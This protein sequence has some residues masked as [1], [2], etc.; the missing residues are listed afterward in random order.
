MIRA[1]AASINT[2]RHTIRRTCSPADG[3]RSATFNVKDFRAM[4]SL[5][6]QLGRPLTLRLEGPGLPLVVEPAFGEGEQLL[7][8]QLV[9]ATLVEAAVPEPMAPMG[10][11]G[12]VEEARLA[13]A[14][15]AGNAG[16][17][18]ICTPPRLALLA[19]RGWVAA[20]KGVQ[21]L[22]GAGG[23]RLGAR[24]A[25]QHTGVR[26]TQIR[27]MTP[28]GRSRVEAVPVAG[29]RQVERLNTTGWDDVQG[30][31]GTLARCVD[32]TGGWSA[33]CPAHPGLSRGLGMDQWKGAPGEPAV[34][35]QTLPRLAHVGDAETSG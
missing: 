10:R 16:G 18:C 9:L 28:S 34:L 8:A 22:V 3:M 20:G 23:G 17:A 14:G 7:E 25:A 27:L 33:T 32:G 15:E 35:G 11:A 24:C 19:W 4:L 31:P 5:C 2:S 13:A 6:E 1:V 26:Q 30:G 12:G 29:L 21:R